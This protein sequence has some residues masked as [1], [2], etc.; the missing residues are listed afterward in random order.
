[1]PDISQEELDQL[2]ARAAR[3]A[4]AEPA[5][6]IS[7]EELDELRARAARGDSV[8][9][10]PL[11]S[12]EELDALRALAAK[13]PGPNGEVPPAVT[14]YA[15]CV[16]GTRHELLNGDRPTHISSTGDDGREIVTA[17]GHIYLAA[18]AR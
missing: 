3:S 7:Q 5:P 13:A 18:P 15:V 10:G 17:V 2:R 1:M 8:A 6:Q 14:G 16:D 9:A 11:I 4:S 12:Q